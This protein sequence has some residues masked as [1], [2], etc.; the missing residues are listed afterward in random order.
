MRTVVITACTGRKRLSPPRGLWARELAIGAIE[1][2]ARDWLGRLGAADD[3]VPACRLY[4][5]RGFAESVSATQAIGASLFIVS[6]GLGL[7]AAETAVPGYS[8]TITPRSPDNILRR[9]QPTSSASAWWREIA[10][11]STVSKRFTAVAESHPSGLILFALPSLYLSMVEEDL[12]ELPQEVLARFRFFGLGILA[13]IDPRLESFVMPY[14]ERLEDSGSRFRGTRSDFAPRALRHFAE[15]V[16]AG[17]SH[18]D[19]QINIAPP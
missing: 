5:G 18:T 12:L 8:L 1:H 4:C 13:R 2:V 14:D 11:L 17:A 19:Q 3:H 6:A 15:V 16:L 10:T 9:T 7:V